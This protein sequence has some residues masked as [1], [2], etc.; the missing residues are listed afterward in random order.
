MILNIPQADSQSLA[1][2]ISFPHG[3]RMI[4]HQTISVFRFTTIPTIR[5]KSGSKWI[6][7]DRWYTHVYITAIEWEQN[8]NTSTQLIQQLLPWILNL[9]FFWHQQYLRRFQWK[10]H[11][12]PKNIH[13][14]FIEKP[15]CP[16]T[17][18]GSSQL[19]KS[20]Q[21]PQ[22]FS[23]KRPPPWQRHGGRVPVVFLWYC[24]RGQ[25][26]SET[27]RWFKYEH[28]TR[29]LGLSRCLLMGS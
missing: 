20:R 28:L 9:P 8:L 29:Q 18:C 10:S 4:V 16:R 25:K 21:W 24:F 19:A 5:M 22:G 6:N 15:C 17:C 3:K 26:L 23:K 1:G 11:R 13:W 2:D 12:Y 7:D 14:F 27:A